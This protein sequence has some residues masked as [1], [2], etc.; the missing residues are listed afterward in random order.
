MM[1]RRLSRSHSVSL[2]GSPF[3]G[4]GGMTP[5]STQIPVDYPI[6]SLDL[7]NFN[8]EARSSSSLSSSSTSSLPYDLS[9]ESGGDDDD[10]AAS[11]PSLG[12]DEE[13]EEKYDLFAVREFVKEN[14]Y[15]V[16]AKDPVVEGQGKW[17]MFDAATGVS[18]EVKDLREVVTPNA[19]LLF[20]RRR[21]QA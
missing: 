14:R 17:A 21:E 7:G 15:R 10:L 2:P 1:A 6:E 11:R 19:D 8:G 3:G 13:E 5:L 4:L 20:Y 18:R 16:F 12:S 9:S